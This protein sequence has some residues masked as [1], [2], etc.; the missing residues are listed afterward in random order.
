MK[1]ISILHFTIRTQVHLYHVDRKTSLQ[2]K[3]MPEINVEKM[4]TRENHYSATI[5][6]ITDSEN[7]NNQ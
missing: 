5:N 2:K 6:E 4:V 1:R 3:K 7:Q